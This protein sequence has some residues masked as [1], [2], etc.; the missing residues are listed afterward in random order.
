MKDTLSLLA[1]LIGMGATLIVQPASTNTQRQSTPVIQQSDFHPTSFTSELEAVIAA[2]SLYN[3]RSIQEDREYIGGIF[4]DSKQRRF[5]FSAIGGVIGKNRIKATLQ[6]P[7]HLKLVSLWHTHG[8]GKGGFLFFSRQ[9][10]KLVM[11]L[12]RPLYLADSSG[13]LKKLSPGD[14]TLSRSQSYK[15]GLGYKEGYAKGIKVKD[16]KNAFIRI[17]TALPKS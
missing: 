17:P 4:K 8:A 14:P 1:M 13:Y 16:A 9:D 15:L 5:Y 11:T 6:Y 10:R 3:P 7:G 2:T 12:N